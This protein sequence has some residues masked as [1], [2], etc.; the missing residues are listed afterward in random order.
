MEHNIE[1]FAIRSIQLMHDKKIQDFISKV[2]VTRKQIVDAFDKT[3]YES[4]RKEL[5]P[6]RQNGKGSKVYYR[7]SDILKLVE[8]SIHD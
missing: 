4:I 3:T 7:V 2:Q 1:L 6:V 5:R 8:L